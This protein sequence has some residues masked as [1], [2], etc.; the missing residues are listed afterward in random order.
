MRPDFCPDFKFIK[1]HQISFVQGD[2]GSIETRMNL[3]VHSGN[4]ENRI[5]V[6]LG[7]SGFTNIHSI[8]CNLKE[9]GP[10]APEGRPG[11]GSETCSVD[12]QLSNDYV[13][14]FRK[15]PCFRWFRHI[16][17]GLP[18]WRGQSPRER[19]RTKDFL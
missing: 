1:N 11:G 18:Q 4:H 3:N 17:L 2:K 7:V 14:V 13:W 12:L 8:K 9:D 16:L 15:N 5:I 19:P 6:A 10:A